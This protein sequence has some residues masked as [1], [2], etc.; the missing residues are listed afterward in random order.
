MSKIS[1]VCFYT[2]HD[3]ICL[4]QETVAK[5]LFK[6]ACLTFYKYFIMRNTYKFQKYNPLGVLEHS[7]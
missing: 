2:K 5:K 3:N 7:L 6:V 4:L 1:K